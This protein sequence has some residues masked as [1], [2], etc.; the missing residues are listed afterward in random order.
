[1]SSTTMAI[2]NKENA[3]KSTG[4]RT[5]E[6]KARVAGNA[7]KHGLASVRV[8]IT[9]EDERTWLLH[10]AQIKIDFAPATA[11][12]NALTDHIANAQ[13]RLLRVAR[14]ETEIID[15]ALDGNV[16]PAMLLF[17]KTPDEALARLHRYEAQTRR[18]LST[19]TKDLLQMQKLR[20]SDGKMTL[21]SL[22]YIRNTM[23]TLDLNDGCEFDETKPCAPTPTPETADPAT[24]ATV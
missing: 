20:T 9:G 2:A 6:G 12:E 10:L 18:A 23:K 11:L 15:A 7:L 5:P 14:W 17:G 24:S 21:R 19:A 13:W 16:A 22:N 4:P 3:Q 1:M 8:I